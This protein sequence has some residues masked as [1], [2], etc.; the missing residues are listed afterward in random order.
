MT[1]KRS[2]VDEYKDKVDFGII[3]IR[4]DEWD[5]LLKRIPRES[6]AIGRQT[7]VISRLQTINDEEYVIASVRCPEPGNGQ[8]QAVART[9]IDELNPQWILLVG[10]AGSLPDYEYTLGDV[11]IASRLHDFCVSA[12]IESGDGQLVQQFAGGGGPMLPEVQSL[13][14]AL[15]VLF[16]EEWN[17]PK[18]LLV[19]R[20]KVKLAPGNFYGDANWKKKVRACLE[21]TLGSRATAIGRKPSPALLRQATPFLKAQQLLANGYLPIAR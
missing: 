20:P 7:Y 13:V 4:E 11:L 18:A 17:S 12:A 8:G 3:T 6:L 5:A 21:V 14:G 9:L 19:D 1:Q 16:L 15:Q 10:I 2:T